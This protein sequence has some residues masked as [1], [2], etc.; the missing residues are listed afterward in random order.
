MDRNPNAPPGGLLPGLVGDGPGVVAGVAGVAA[1]GMR[2]GGTLGPCS[3]CAIFFII[4]SRERIQCHLE[5]DSRRSACQGFGKR[6]GGLGPW[7]PPP[8]SAG[9]GPSGPERSTCVCPRAGRPCDVSGVSEPSP[10]GRRGH[11]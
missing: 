3:S 9:R 11:R 5:S 10:P 4:R 1:G 7:S 6:R 2:R 8:A